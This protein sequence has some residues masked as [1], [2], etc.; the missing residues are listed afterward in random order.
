VQRAPPTSQGGIAAASASPTHGT[1]QRKLTA[2]RDLAG[3][4]S[5]REGEFGLYIGV[6]PGLGGWLARSVVTVRG[7]HETVQ[8]CGRGRRR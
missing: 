7:S 8:V 4:G 3:L 6:E 5:E 2:A 1:P